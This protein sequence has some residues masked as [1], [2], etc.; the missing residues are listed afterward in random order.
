MMNCVKRCTRYTVFVTVLTLFSQNIFP[1]AEAAP[2]REI[3]F[4]TFAAWGAE[5]RASGVIPGELINVTE[6]AQS[7]R[8]QVSK[9]VPGSNPMRYPAFLESM[10]VPAAPGGPVVRADIETYK[11]YLRGFMPAVPVPVVAAAVF[12]PALP[13]HLEGASPELRASLNYL[14]NGPLN[15]SPLLGI[16]R[17]FAEPTC[18]QVGV[19][20]GLM[21]LRTLGGSYAV[22]L[23]PTTT[24][25]S[26]RQDIE[27]KTG[28]PV[29]R[30]MILAVGRNDKIAT[31]LQDLVNWQRAPHVRLIERR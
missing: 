8:K 24:W 23:M 18:E 20:T 10:R 3:N 5:Q 9:A 6:Y 26:L 4:P 31:S 22:E 27:N 13:Q 2:R 28:I 17:D 15:P 21:Y 25:S 1:A 19:E 14:E 7:L 11:D 29:S 30:Q 12:P 16:F